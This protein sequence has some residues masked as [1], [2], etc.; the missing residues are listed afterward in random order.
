MSTRSS[1]RNLFPP[2]DNPEHTIR[3]RSRA[4]PTLLNDFEMAVEGNDDL[5]VP[6]LRTMEELCQPSLNGRGGPISPIAI[7]ATNFRLKNDMVQQVHNS[8]QFHGLPGDDANKHL[9]KFLYVTQSIKVNGVTDDALHLHRDTINAAAGGTLMK[10]RPEECY[11]LIENMTAHHNDWDT[12]AQRITDVQTQNVYA[13][14][15]YQGGNSYQPQGN[16]AILKNMQ[17]NMTS[18]TNSNLELKNMFG[19]FIKINTASSSGSG[20]LPSNTVTNPKEDLKGIITQSGNA[21]Q[22]PTIPTTFSSSPQVVERETE[23]TKDTVPPTNNRRTK[24]VQP[25]VVQ[26]ETPIAILSPLLLPLLSLLLLLPGRSRREHKSHAIIRMEQAFPSRTY[27]TLMT[28]ELVNRLISRPIG[29]AK[30]VFVKVGKFQF[31]ADFVVVDFDADPRVPLILGRS[32]LKTEKALIDV[33]EGELTLRVGKEVVTFNLDQTSRYSANYN[34]M[35]ENRIDVI[36]MACE[37]YSQKVLGFSDVIASGNPTPYYGPIVSNSSST[38][39]LVG[40]SDFLLEEVNAFLALEDDPT[41]PEVD[42]S[43]YDTE[44]EILLLEAFLND[45]PSLPPPTQGMYLPQILKELKICEAKNDKSLIDEPPEVELKDLPPHLEYAFLEGDDK[46]PVIISK[47]LSVK[48]KATLL[49]VLKSH[50]Q[51][52][53][54]KLS[55]IKGINPKVCTHEILMEDDFEPAEKSHFMVKEGIVLGHKISKN[56]IEVDKAKVNVISKLPH[57]TTVKGIRSFI[58]HV[59]FYR[60]FMQDFS[61]IARPMTRLLEK[62]TPFFFSKEDVVLAK[63]QILQR[64]EALLL[65]RPFLFKICA[66]QVIR[67]CV[68]GQE[69]IDILKACH[70]D[71]PGDTMARTTPLKRKANDAILKNM[72]TSMTS[73]TNSNLELINMFGH[74]MKMNIA[75]S[76]GSRTLPVERE[77]KATKDTV[78][79]TNNRSTED[80]QPLVVSTKCPILNSEP[81]VVPIIEPVASTFG[82]SIKSLLTNKD[83]LCEL[84][85]TPL[86][87]HYLV[88]LQKKLPEKLEDSGKLLISCY[89]LEM[90]ECLALTDLG[91]SINLMPLSVW[92]K[93]SLPNS[94]PPCMTLELTDHS[95]SRQVEVAEDVFVKVSTFHFPADFIVVD[96][97]ADPRVPLILGISFLK[98]RRALIDV[99]E[100]NYNDM[101]ANRIDVIDMACEEYSQEVLSFSDVI[102]SGNPTPYYDPI[103]STTS[104]TLTLF[105]NSDFL[106]EEVDAFLALEYDP[107]SLEVDQSYVDT[108][109]DILLLEAF[110]NEDP[111]LP[112]PNQG[113]YLPQ[114]RKEQKIFEAKS[115]KSSID[116]PPEV[117]HKDLPPHLEHA[118]MDGD[119]KLPVIIAKDLSVEEKTALITIL[120]SHKQAIAWKLSDIKGIDPEFCTHKIL[121][122]EDFKPAVQHQRRVNPKIHNVIKQEVLK[123]LDV[124][125]M[126][127]DSPWKID[128]NIPF[129]L[130]CNASDFA[131]G[132]VLGKR[133]EK[134]FRPIY[135]DSKTITEVE[136]NY[137]P[138]EKEMLAVVYAFEKFQSYLI[139]NKSI[140]YTDNSALKYLFARKDSKARLLCWILLLQE[141]IFKVIHTKGAENLATDHLSRLENPH[142][143]FAKVMIKFGDT[144]SLATP[145]HPQTSCQVEVSN[146][147]LKRILERTVGEN[148]ASWS[149]K[150]DDTLWAFRTAY[151]TPIGCTLYKLVYGKACHLLIELENKAYWALKYVNFDLQTVGDHKKVQV[152]EL[153]ELR[154]QAY[155]NSLIYK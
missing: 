124:G 33:Y 79:P 65:G 154:D 48:E 77:T 135:Y 72:Q 113:N 146:C 41:S 55:D 97:D 153:N 29:V 68:H 151:K 118:F 121:T 49:K 26:V 86:N 125:L 51:A 76:S 14:G 104:L 88:V 105:G 106:L 15:A 54:W 96:F 85:G 32:F 78:H 103:V 116:K 128:S 145:Y 141:F 73:L 147:G 19:Q 4:D 34:D 81:V 82:P 36:D 24:D 152:N 122:E 57:P 144:Q 10:R 112:P 90:A 53:A 69:A 43:Y 136:S 25:P 134:H 1:A 133:Q 47:E 119:D 35:T 138:T 98:T 94:S 62:D 17:T 22:G 131:I 8:C 132:A 9:D 31:P 120:K 13:A 56:G 20:T 87:E 83:K 2:L 60:R 108:E 117:E 127:F 142:Q 137:T 18:L 149:D 52:I 58:G 37:E 123:L 42:H 46:L 74:F 101:T 143:N 129:E 64:C 126:I 40:D 28:L 89:F 45:D 5:P 130:M 63:E 11:D 84:T 114:V 21:Y 12:L 150:L 30:D 75:S 102:A 3:R 99:F 71:P 67:R 7:Q 61:K 66:D 91:T 80:V 50:K 155:E 110:L 27:S 139:M 115:D 6:D 95:I 107:T 109:G 93:L 100:V 16:D 44:G 23:V 70:N 92:N 148:H 38:L 140:V 111:S 39:T 59:G